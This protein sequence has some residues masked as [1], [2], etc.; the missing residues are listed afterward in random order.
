VSGS[1]A[2]Q[3][4]SA[5]APDYTALRRRLVPGYDEF[6]GAVVDVLRLVDGCVDVGRVLDLGAGTGLLS[7]QVTG[8]FP[9]VRIELLDG[10]EPMLREARGRLGDAVSAVH[11]L[12]MAGPLPA[13]PFDAIVSA[14]AIHHLEHDDKRA[15]MRRA[16]GQL[17]PGGVFVNADQVSA[18]TPELTA[19]YEQRWARECRALGATESELDAARERMRHDRCVDVEPQLRW[20]REAGFSTVDCVYKSWRFAVMAGFKEGS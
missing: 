19:A 13:G 9:G 11:V 15:L 6:Y 20:L 2:A 7:E 16:H 4:F 10:S 14:L 12:D 1:A 17:R 8:A 3:A 18:P 5:H